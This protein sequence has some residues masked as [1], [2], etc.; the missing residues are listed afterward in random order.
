M[1]DDDFER[2]LAAMPKIAEAVQALPS[3]LQQTAYG[4]LV[5]AFRGESATSAPPTGDVEDARVSSSRDNQQVGP[6]EEQTDP[7]RRPARKTAARRSPTRK[8]WTPDRTIDFWP[9]GKQ[10]FEDFAKEKQ[11]QSIDQKNLVS[12]H[13]LEQVAEL[14][15][16]GVS[17]VL[18]AYKSMDW[19]EPANAVNS[20]QVTASQKHWLETKDMKK[21]VTTPVG[22]NA[23]KSMPLAKAKK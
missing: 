23:I 18:A 12:V 13:W 8:S 19:H 14:A 16:I 9:E 10:S 11:P 15:E 4:D 21:I 20:L 5:A 2:L 1:A 6:E 22:R 17:Q 7:Q 3:E